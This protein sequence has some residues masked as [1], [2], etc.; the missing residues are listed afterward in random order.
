MGFQSSEKEWISILEVAKKSLAQSNPNPM[1]GTWTANMSERCVEVPWAAGHLSGEQRILD[2]GWSMSSPEWIGVVLEAINQ[3]AE[4]IGIDII[5][6]KR[7]VNRYPQEM[8]ADV[9]AVPTRVEDFMNAD[10]AGKMFDTITCISTLEHIGFDMATPPDV[11]ESVFER[12]PDPSSAPRLRDTTTDE[13]F[14][15]SVDRF[16]KPGGQLL[17]SVPIGTGQ[18]ILHR[19][20]L[21][22]YTSQFEYDSRTWNKLMAQH[23]YTVAD[24]RFFTH[25]SVEGWQQ[26]W[27]VGAVGSRSS[28]LMPFALGCAVAKLVKL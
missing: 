17:V 7:V 25:D 27:D 11:T 12:S 4:V 22:L 5:D 26:V 9:L 3:G 6:P 23:G 13:K 16:L 18:P 1:V 10:P 20:S 24:E 21:G 2:I 19:D 15:M 28:A 14:M 8:K